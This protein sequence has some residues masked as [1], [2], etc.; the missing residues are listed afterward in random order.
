MC[1]SNSFWK[2]YIDIL[3]REY[4]I[5]FYWP[6]AILQHLKVTHCTL[7][8]LHSCET[9]QEVER[10]TEAKSE[11]ERCACVGEQMALQAEPKL[12]RETEGPPVAGP[13]LEILATPNQYVNEI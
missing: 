9:E 13:V 6:H 2:P 11:R 5:P 8:L 4:N 12:Q 7:A 3:P 1:S 10:E